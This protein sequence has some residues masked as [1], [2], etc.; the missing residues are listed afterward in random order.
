MADALV[1]HLMRLTADGRV[2]TDVIFRSTFDPSTLDPGYTV[3]SGDCW[4]KTADGEVIAHLVTEV[5]TYLGIDGEELHA[6]L[7]PIK[8]VAIR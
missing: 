4:E 7:S 6:F 5:R 1:F 2:G 3:E 8:E